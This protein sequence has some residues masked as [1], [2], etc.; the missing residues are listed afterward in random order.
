MAQRRW[1]GGACRIGLAGRCESL[2]VYACLACY[3]SPGWSAGGDMTQAE[4]DLLPP[5]CRGQEHVANQYFK[6]DGGKWKNI[7]GI[8]YY[9]FHHYCWGLVNLGKAYKSGISSEVRKGLLKTSIGDIMYSID[10]SSS[11]FVLLP[12]MYTRIGQ[13]LLG[14]G[15]ERQAETAFKRAWQANPEYWPPYVWWAQHL[16]R[17]GKTREAL[18][19]AEDGKKNAPDSKALDN[20]IA[21]IRRA[22]RNDK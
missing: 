10:R 9:H 2:F 8:D 19:I 7:L 13:A 16:L 18:A 6:P 1:L 20:I 22:A 14:L 12:E 4:Y 17:Q 21:D 5:Y 15:E 11:D 3:A